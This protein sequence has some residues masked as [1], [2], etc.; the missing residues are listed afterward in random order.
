[1]TL[2]ESKL[3]GLMLAQLIYTNP[4]VVHHPTKPY[5][6]PANFGEARLPH[7]GCA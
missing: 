6:V 4:Y 1:M 2:E 3:L 5:A 7:V